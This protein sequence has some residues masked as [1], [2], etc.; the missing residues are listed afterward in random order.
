MPFSR[1]FTMSRLKLLFYHIVSNFKHDLSIDRICYLEKNN[2][3][4][5][6]YMVGMSNAG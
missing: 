4:D 5:T 3:L 1:S 6:E 2:N